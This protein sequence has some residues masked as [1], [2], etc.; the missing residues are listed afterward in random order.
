MAH[1]DGAVAD[2]LGDK[3]LL[4]VGDADDTVPPA[5]ETAKI[6]IPGW[7]QC[8]TIWACAASARPSDNRRATVAM[9]YRLHNSAG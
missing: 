3:A 8:F 7:L 6:G 9:S 2:G 1:L 4:L 5:P